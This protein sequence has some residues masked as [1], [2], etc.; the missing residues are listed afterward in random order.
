MYRR[1]TS[2]ATSAAV[3]LAAAV[4]L[5]P[6]AAQAAPE[7]F[8]GRVQVIVGDTIVGCAATFDE[9]SDMASSTTTESEAHRVSITTGLRQELVLVGDPTRVL[10]VYNHDGA[11]SQSQ[12]DG[13]TFLS[14]GG[15]L[16][17]GTPSVNGRQTAIWSIDPASR[18]LSAT[19]VWDDAST[20]AVEAWHYD[21]GVGANR[22]FIG[23][24]P[25]AEAFASRFAQGVVA[26]LRI[27]EACS[28]PVVRDVAQAITF[29]SSVPSPAYPGQTYTVAATGGA[30]GNAVTF[31]ST[32]SEVCSIDGSTVILT[33]PGTCTIDANQAA[34]TGYSAAPT[35]SQDVTVSSIPTTTELTL[36]RDSVV[37]G[38]GFTAT[39]QIDVASGSI[40]RAGGVVAFSIDG[41]AVDHVAFD[42][43]GRATTQAIRPGVGVHRI[44]AAWFPENN[45]EYDNS[46]DESSLTVSAA[47]TSTK[48]AVKATELSATVAPVAPGAGTPTG[49]VAFFVDGTKV[50]TATLANGTAKLAHRI[51]TDRTHAVSA[52]YAGSTD[53]NASSA[54][55]SRANPTLTARVASS[56][57]SRGGWYRHPVTISFD[58]DA[59]GAELATACPKPV[60]VSRQ[61]ATSVTR[62]IHTADGGI[63]TVTA[64]VKLDRSKPRVGI[65]GVKT[66]R[67]YFD[68]PKPTCSAKDSL[69]GVKTCKVT[70]KRSGSRVVV[71][72]K[73]TD[74]AGNVRTKR[75]AYRIASHEIQGAKLK[76]GT[77]RVKHGETYTIRVRGAKA[78]YVYATPAPG[79]PHR[80]SVPFKKAGK[81]TW[82]LGVTM[83]MTTS[84]T[85]SWNLGYTQNGKLHV[86]KVKVTG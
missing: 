67:S 81:N 30:S 66:G 35:V 11:M 69:S 18:E 17:A 22:R 78:N 54:S 33:K 1:V 34:A 9:R 70:T 31:S 4:A 74:V 86:I 77:Y 49:D 32:T 53:F 24:A 84:A 50:G 36:D 37:T 58:C 46:S 14:R 51:P 43:D 76:N 2:I 75:V 23:L 28:G 27:G 61:G 13:Y 80:G 3:G 41:H 56:Q 57:K 52:E 29:T 16:P 72:A 20:Q 40:G 59:K 79:K 62:T 82:A 73:A 25:S 71:T 21:E 47:S 26:S 7:T 48:V 60:K 12:P 45:G 55:T 15:P 39:A 19:Y 42:G 8:T 85:R 10:G 6:T 44:G 5:L 63:V 38:Q 65:R 64:A 68:A 83:S